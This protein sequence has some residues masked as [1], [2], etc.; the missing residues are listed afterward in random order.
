MPRKVWL[1]VIAMVINVTGASFLWPFNT[2]YIHNH[3]GK[4]LSVAGMALLINSLAGVVGNLVGGIMFDKMGGYTSIL[5]GIL[6]TLSAVTGLVFF[7]DWPLYV[8]WLGIIGL[9]AGMVFPSMY[10][11]VGAVWPEG[12]RRAFNAMYIG[13]NVG[14]AVGS[15]LGGLV[16]S[17]RIDYIFLANLTLYFVFFMIALISFK[18]MQINVDKVETK[19]EK[20]SWKL[21]PSL[22]ALLVMCIAYAICWI[23][24][25]QWQVTISAH[26][27]DLDISLR[28]YSL[29]WT[30]NGAL[31]VL[32]QPVVTA[33]IRRFNRSLKQQILIGT[34]IF[35]VSF[36]VVGQAEQFSMFMTGMLILTIG[37]MFVWPAVPTIA[38]EL[39]P[40]GKIGFYQGVVNSAATG[41]RMLGPWMGGLIVDLYN[42][43]VLF[44]VLMA[45]L[46]IAMVATSL[47][48]YKLKEKQT[49]EKIAV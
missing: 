43:Q 10:A 29:L 48:D 24:Y 32:A 21:T 8:V 28:A 46:L 6:I 14:V 2:I 44:M 45:M 27:Q 13:Q 42:I 17:F 12:G 4:S 5:S 11:M 16:A 20:A 22:Q 38:N 26:M 39:A 41:G 1:L 36:L 23:A 49:K 7:H 33:F 35:I 30:V 25:V 19:V 18:D 40:E 9:G 3:L 15:A 47:Y 31:I 37:E 34:S